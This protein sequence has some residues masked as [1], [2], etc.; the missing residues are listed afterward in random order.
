MLSENKKGKKAKP[1]RKE[2]KKER[3]W[4]TNSVDVCVVFIIYPDLLSRSGAER[5]PTWTNY[6]WKITGFNGF[7]V[8]VVSQKN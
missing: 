6:K 1:K 5:T 7:N 4:K 3:R 2:L 8:D